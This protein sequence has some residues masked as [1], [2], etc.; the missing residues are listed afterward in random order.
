MAKTTAELIAEFEARGG[1]ARKL[2]TGDSNNISSGRWYKA[3][4]GEVDLSEQLKDGP[5]PERKPRK[6]KPAREGEVFYHSAWKRTG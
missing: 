4:Q 6:A 2:E 3:A 1:K 5:L